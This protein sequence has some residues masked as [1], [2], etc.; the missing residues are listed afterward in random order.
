[1]YLPPLYPFCPFYDVLLSNFVS[2]HGIMRPEAGSYLQIVV[3]V[4]T[5]LLQ[6]TSRQV[7]TANL[8]LEE[9]RCELIIQTELFRPIRILMMKEN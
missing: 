9:W 8:W 7:L 4:P 2:L 3:I 5:L 1:M 6:T